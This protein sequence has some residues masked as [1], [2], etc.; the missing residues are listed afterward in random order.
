MG[1]LNDLTG[2]QF[3]RLVVIER[4]GTYQSPDQYDPHTEPTW[5]CLCDPKL[6]GCG[7]ECIVQGPNL[8]AGKTR[9]C[10]CLRAE[11]AATRA[12]ERKRART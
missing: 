8:R 3:G 6:G 5:R 10:G 9:S 7:N 1:K 11:K 4:A 12:A 2:R